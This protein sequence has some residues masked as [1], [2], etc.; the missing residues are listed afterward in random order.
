MK[1]VLTRVTELGHGILHSGESGHIELWDRLGPPHRPT[2]EEIGIYKDF[3][4]S[5]GVLPARL[6]IFGATPELRDLAA[7]LGIRAGV[8]DIEPRFFTG[9][10]RFCRVARAEHETWIKGDW[11]TDI[12]PRGRYEAILGDLILRNVDVSEQERLLDNIAE[13]CAAHGRLITRVHYINSENIRRSWEEI[14][15]DAAGSSYA[16]KK[17][18]VMGS[19]LS[20]LFDKSTTR[21]RI[22][23]PDIRQA[24]GLY[25]KTKSQSLE[26][27]LFLSEF[28]RKR[29]RGAK[30]LASQTRSEIEDLLQKHFIIEGARA[31][32]SY[33]ESEFYPIYCLRRR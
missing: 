27:R 19:L 8:F 17:Y 4:M 15:D 14:F 3:L 5:A 1:D 29:V 22:S 18:E 9:F 30:L 10:L 20:R 24:I 31:A 13:A 6:V 21:S 26:Y 16:G 12:L 28:L 2:D 25:L 11:L 33:P 32:N 7:G 23:P